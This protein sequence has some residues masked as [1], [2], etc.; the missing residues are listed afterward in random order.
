[1]FPVYLSMFRQ[2]WNASL[3]LAPSIAS[4]DNQYQSRGDSLLHFASIISKLAIKAHYS[5]AC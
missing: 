1:M 4:D 3:P 5:G 2:A